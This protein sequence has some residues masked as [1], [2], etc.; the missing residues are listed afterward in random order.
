MNAVY[1]EH[2]TA[3]YPARSTVAVK[4]LPLG[5]QV[6]IEL[7][8]R[9]PRNQSPEG[10]GKEERHRLRKGPVGLLTEPETQPTV[11]SPVTPKAK[12]PL[13]FPSPFR[14]DY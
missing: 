13:L 7:V 6:E 10:R 5:T 3:P 12:A 4:A 8:A 2:F 11:P 9:R 1:A 14:G